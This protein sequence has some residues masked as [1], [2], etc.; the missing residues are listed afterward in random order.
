M[1]EKKKL[2]FSFCSIGLAVVLFMALSPSGSSDFSEDGEPHWC[3]VCKEIIPVTVG[4]S[5]KHSEKNPGQ[6]MT[7]PQCNKGVLILGKKCA[8]N[9][10]FYTHNQAAQKKDGTAI[11]PKCKSEIP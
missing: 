2:I 5:L 8:V 10:C 7:C 1:S 6:A 4:D 11:C 3:G 9:G